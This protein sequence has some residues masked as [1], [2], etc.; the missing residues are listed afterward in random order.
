MGKN[1]GHGLPGKRHF[2]PGRYLGGEGVILYATPAERGGRGKPFGL[3]PTL[4][5]RE[6]AERPII[7]VMLRSPACAQGVTA[8]QALRAM[9]GYRRPASPHRAQALHRVRLAEVGPSVASSIT[10]YYQ[11]IPPLSTVRHSPITSRPFPPPICL[12]A[13]GRLEACRKPLLHRQIKRFIW[14]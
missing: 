12:P 5:L 8:E 9:G 1:H 7:V 14:C 3:G 4:P 10:S 6:A 11:P 13:F 2:T